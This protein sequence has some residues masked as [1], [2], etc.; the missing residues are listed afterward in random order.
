M[1]QMLQDSFR[2]SQTISRDFWPFLAMLPDALGFL[3]I[4][5]D[6]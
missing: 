3:G 2:D 1:L 4:L 5:G 6:S